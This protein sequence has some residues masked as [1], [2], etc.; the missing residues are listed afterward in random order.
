MALILLWAGTIAFGI[1]AGL[2]WCGTES[3]ALRYGTASIGG[4]LAFLLAI[5]SWLRYQKGG[6]LTVELPPNRMTRSDQWFEGGGGSFD[7]GGATGRW[8][9]GTSSS[10]GLDI[11]SDGD[12]ILLPLIVVLVSLVAALSVASYVIW[13]APSLLAEVLV[14]G[15]IMTGIYRRLRDQET[16]DWVSGVVRRTW[17]PAML[18]TALV[19]GGGALIQYRVPSAQTLREALDY[20]APE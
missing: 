14:D 8:D 11:P 9:S 17:L 15:A 2:L 6:H 16:P 18:L 19:S 4:Y 7:G 3:M 20:R 5:G 1:S 12:E 13:I 10:G